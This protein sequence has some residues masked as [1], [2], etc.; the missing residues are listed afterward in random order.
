[1][2]NYHPE[3]SGLLTAIWE[4]LSTLTDHVM[5]ARTESNESRAET[6]KRLS[7]IEMQ[8]L[9]GHHR[10]NDIERRQKAK[11][12]GTATH[13]LGFLK[14]VATPKE[15]L[16]AVALVVL[17]LKGSFQPGEFKAVILSI[18]GVGLN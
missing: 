1:M 9:N 6:H 18:L 14:E 4:R 13:F 17:A 2:H 7:S 8:L 16:A 15:W 5:D 11:P 3:L 10:M 12:P